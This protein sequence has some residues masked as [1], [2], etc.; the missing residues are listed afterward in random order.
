MTKNARNSNHLQAV[1][2][3]RMMAV[4]IPLPLLETFGSIESSFF[5]LC[6]DSGQQVLQ[7]QYDL[8]V[9][10]DRDGPPP[11]RGPLRSLGRD[12]GLRGSETT[13]LVA[14]FSLAQCASSRFQLQSLVLP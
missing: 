4:E 9:S 6:I 5:E 11:R 7:R 12:S 10:R 1:D 8:P 13:R 14:V 3:P 2:L